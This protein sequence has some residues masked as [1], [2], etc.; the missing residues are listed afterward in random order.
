MNE[1]L[2]HTDKRHPDYQQ[3]QK[4]LAA[5]QAITS[6]LDNNKEL[7]ENL[8]R[9]LELETAL[10]LPHNMSRRLIREGVFVYKIGEKERN[11]ACYLFNDCLVVAKKKKSRLSGKPSYKLLLQQTLHNLESIDAGNIF[12]LYCSFIRIPDEDANQLWIKAPGKQI[13]LKTASGNIS[14]WVR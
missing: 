14:E 9:V 3:I 4:A 5:T 8:E 1:L 11:I 2:K 10:K 13:T 7:S 12:P 6:Q